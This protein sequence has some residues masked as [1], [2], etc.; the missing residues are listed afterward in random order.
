MQA[1]MN[2]RPNV[3]LIC[4]DHW[5]A[6]LRA[7]RGH[8]SVLTPTVDALAGRGVEFTSMYSEC[9]VC[10]PARRGIMTGTFP[11]THGDR[12]YSDRMEMPDV[13]TLAETFH[14]AGYQTSAVGKLH[15]YPQ[16]NRIGFEEALITEEARY[17]FGVT[18]DYQIWLGEHG[19]TG[20]EFLHGMPSNMYYTRPWHLPEETHV[21]NWTAR[22]MAKQIKRSDPTRPH[23]FYC[24][25]T[26]PHPP[27]VPPQPYL[28]MY[29]LQDIDEPYIG[30][31]AEDR[32][33]PIQALRDMGAPYTEKEVRLARRAFYASCT[34]ID[35]QIRL[36]I[37]TLREMSL[38]DNTIIAFLSDHGD[39]LFNH[40]MVAKRVF[41]E[42][43]SHV[44]FFVTGKPIAERGG[45][46]DNRLVC[47]ADIMPTLLD[48]ADIPVPPTVEGLSMFG[49]KKRQLLYGELGEGA[50]ATRMATDGRYKLIY[51]PTGNYTQLFDLQK[52]PRE[53]TNLTGSQELRATEERLTAHLLEHMHGDD[54]SWIDGGRLVG[55][56][57]REFAPLQDF[58]LYNQRG[59]HW[60][61]PSGYTHLGGDL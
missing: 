20:Q 30:E 44:P 23:F 46:R 1:N 10:I 52:D 4:T 59:Y 9:P 36:V 19:Y 16:R 31:W 35:H 15:V 27:L 11:K 17:D 54:L 28:D 25:F 13:P 45:T 32:V 22:Q 26:A 58:S 40:G 3:L 8:P 34:Q 38:L 6:E 12:V 47:L 18:D 7:S 57:N 2:D 42:S 14:Q 60:P 55:R 29:D 43:S 61:P 24:S 48:L 53:L 37:G 49:P 5:P 51:Y 56:E 21:T 33:Y 39:M 41:Y 50:K